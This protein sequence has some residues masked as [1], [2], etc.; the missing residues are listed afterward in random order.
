VT[1][2]LAYVMSAIGS[3]L[4]LLLT[5][6][7]RMAE[8]ASRARWLLGA[9]LSIGG[10]GIWVMHFIAMMGF[11]VSGSQIRYNVPLTAL[12]ALV[13]VLV[14]GGGLFL[15][16]RGG[17][18]VPYLLGGGL[19]AGLGV[20]AMHYLGMFAMNMTAYVNYDPIVVTLSVLIA[21][22]AA[23]VALWF[24]VRIEG[25][26]ATTGAALMMGVAVTG[27]HYTG[28]FAM[29]VRLVAGGGVPAGA[30]AIDF[31]LP[32]LVGISL[33]T[34]G[35]LL[36]VLLSPSERELREDAEMLARLRE[37]SHPAPVSANGSEPESGSFFVPRNSNNTHRNN[38]RS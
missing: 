13:A 24:T 36:S 38:T 4:G 32:L 10:T 31:L 22:V 34:M 30:R 7:A 23:T 35:L 29:S 12:S 11:D 6:R 1:P 8:G 28:M 16:S 26:I 5:S 9:A 21:V 20:A 2:V 18:R 27:M 33:L 3:L 25:A 17:G 14:V 19:L 37:R 15:V